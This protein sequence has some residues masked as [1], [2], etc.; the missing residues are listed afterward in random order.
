MKYVCFMCTITWGS[1]G[2]MKTLHTCMNAWSLVIVSSV[3]IYGLIHYERKPHLAFH[4]TPPVH[5]HPSGWKVGFIHRQ[6]S[7]KTPTRVRSTNGRSARY[8]RHTEETVSHK[9]RVD[10]EVCFN[11]Q[12]IKCPTVRRSQPQRERELLGKEMKKKQK[13]RLC[14]YN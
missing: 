12:T 14:F 10:S 3:I 11:S 4:T 1:I 7:P 8:L 6:T 2:S 5:I 13:Y 9:E